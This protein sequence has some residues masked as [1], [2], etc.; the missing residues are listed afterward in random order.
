MFEKEALGFYYKETRLLWH[1]WIAD[2]FTKLIHCHISQMISNI[3]QYD[4]FRDQ[5]HVPV[6]DQCAVHKFC[7]SS[8]RHTCSYTDLFQNF[9]GYYANFISMALKVFEG[10]DIRVFVQLMW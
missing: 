5:D 10:V 1:D 4:K 7:N 6:K 8:R 3:E 2:N 9:G